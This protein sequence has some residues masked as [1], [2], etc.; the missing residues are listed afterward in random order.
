MSKPVLYGFDG[1]TYVRSVRMLLAEKGA[2]YEQVPVDVLKGEPKEPEHLARHPFGK[3]PV[4]DIDGL[5]ILETPSI[6]RYVNDTVAGPSFV[7]DSPAMRAR[8][9]TAMSVVDA[10]GYAAMV[11][12]AAYHHFPDFIGGRDEA[13]QRER[14]GQARKALG[15]LMSLKGDSPFIAGDVR[16][17]ADFYLA[18]P[19][20]YVSLTDEAREAFDVPGFENW[21]QRVQELESFRTTAPDLG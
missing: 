5:R 10:Y 19:V 16:S 7:P 11:G 8:M 12:L 4:L 13:A 6:L 20:A 9:D 21:W 1:S 2:D 15:Y 14:V 3:V 17:L 18:P